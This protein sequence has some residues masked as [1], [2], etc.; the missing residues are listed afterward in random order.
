MLVSIDKRYPGHARKIMSAFWGLG[1]LMFSKTIIV[2][3]KDVDVQNEAEVAWIVGTH[4]D[5]ER[6]IQFTRG[7]VDDLEDASDLPAIGSKMGIDATRKWAV[8]RLQ[9]DLAEARVRRRP[10]RDAKAE[11][12]WA[13]AQQGMEGMTTGTSGIEAL[14]ERLAGGAVATEDDARLMLET[15]DLIAVGVIAD[16]VRRRLH[17]DRVTFV[18]VLEVHVDRVPAT[19][20]PAPPLARFGS[21]ARRRRWTRHALPS[22]PLERSRRRP[23]SPASRSPIS[24]ISVSVRSASY[25][26]RL[27]DAGLDGIAEVAA[28]SPVRCRAV[29][30]CRTGRRPRR[31]SSHRGRADRL[32][33]GSRCCRALAIC[34][35]VLAG[36]SAF[37]PLPREM[38]IAAPTTGYDDVKLIAAARLLV[39]TIPSIQVDW[40]LYGPKLAQVALDDGRRRCRWRCR[41][42][43]GICSGPAAAR[44]RRFAATSARPG[45][46][47]S[48]VTAGSPLSG[49]LDP[50]H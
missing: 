12:I 48:S 5:P 21:S 31:P 20:P 44:S 33:R 24:P 10:K 41:G 17:D 49:S 27:K 45:S 22:A 28:R 2:V 36:S 46:S 1:Q 38:S 43:S 9:A 42:R 6:D 8:G 30:R 39:S 18:R 4:Y 29:D 35:P 26:A 47:R 23:S 40:S 34:R 37:A 11:A 15:P 25:A 16:D 50:C 19:L 14:A 32:S 13:T 7:P 3:D